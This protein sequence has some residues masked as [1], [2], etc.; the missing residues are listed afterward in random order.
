MHPSQR[1]KS[2]PDNCEM[3]ESQKQNISFS[4]KHA[5]PVPLKCLAHVTVENSKHLE[6]PP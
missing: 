2:K 6:C 1:G 5:Q 4:P 3:S